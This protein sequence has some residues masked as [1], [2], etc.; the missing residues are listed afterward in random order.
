MRNADYGRGKCDGLKG[1]TR[2]T[3]TGGTRAHGRQQAYDLGY[4]QGT[5]ELRIVRG[6]RS[7]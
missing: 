7:K 5:A 2:D 4:N 6:K 1:L 3:P